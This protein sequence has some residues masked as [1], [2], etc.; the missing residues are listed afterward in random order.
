[1]CSSDL[2]LIGSTP[3][4]DDHAIVAAML[5]DDIEKVRTL[6]ARRAKS[7][8]QS[9]LVLIAQ[10][11]LQAPPAHRTPMACAIGRGMLDVIDADPM[12]LAKAPA[13]PQPGVIAPTG[14]SFQRRVDPLDR[15]RYVRIPAR[16]AATIIERGL[17]AWYENA[18]LC[19]T[20]ML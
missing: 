4:A 12:L 5:L 19:A 13:A 17:D 8:A 7:Q 10:P 3:T 20:A 11:W 18:E 2:K 16:I 1:V 6:T 14:T 15:M 9:I